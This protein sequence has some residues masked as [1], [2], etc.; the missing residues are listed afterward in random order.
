MKD[1]FE[2]LRDLY[3]DVGALNKIRNSGL[4]KKE[5]I[6]DAAKTREEFVAAYKNMLVKLKGSI[7]PN[8]DALKK[9]IDEIEREKFDISFQVDKDKL[10]EQ[11]KT[12]EAALD[13][14]GDAWSRF[15]TLQE[16]GFTKELAGRF[17]FGQ[18][19]NNQSNANMADDLYARLSLGMNKEL[20]SG[21]ENWDDV[22]RMNSEEIKKA[23]GYNAEAYSPVL[24]YVEAYQKANKEIKSEN[25]KLF[26]DLYKS[27]RDYAEKVNAVEKKKQKDIATIRE[28]GRGYNELKAQYEDTKESLDFAK[29][30]LDFLKPETEEYKKQ[31]K[32]IAKLEAR[33][34]KLNEKMGEKLPPDVVERLVGERKKQALEDVGKGLLRQ[35]A[36]A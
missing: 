28:Q 30:R 36:E 6:P 23:Y 10:D 20:P 2:K 4:F 1:V 21:V 13:R 15:K 11:V 9:L 31:E 3:G 14:A 16:G 12:L 18:D 27:S 22:L 35:L 29:Q 24:K 17:A 33:F 5:F 26:T 32:F 7:K 25:D 34:A 19:Y 8:S